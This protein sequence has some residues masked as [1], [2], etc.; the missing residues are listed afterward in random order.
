MIIDDIS[1]ESINVKDKKY[2]ERY[3]WG[4]RGL[5]S[6]GAGR[7]ELPTSCSQSRRANRAAL[8][9]EFFDEQSS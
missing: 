6:V 8:R 1:S 2:G 9:P 3:K 5:K 7:F 4:K